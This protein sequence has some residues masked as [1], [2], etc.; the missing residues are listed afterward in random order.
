MDRMNELFVRW[1]AFYGSLPPQRRF[2]L[3][4]SLVASLALTGA[5][6]AWATNDPMV[7]LFDQPLDPKTT[8]QVI[9][10]LKTEQIKYRLERGTD[11]ILVPNHQKVGCVRALS[12]V[13]A[14]VD[15]AG[16]Q[17]MLN[18]AQKLKLDDK[19]ATDGVT[20]IEENQ[21]PEKEK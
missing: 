17:P 8:A 2:S 21:E 1:M 6:V 4:M 7:A 5:V 18:D 11:R 19:P 13:H 3:V 10:Q 14:I 20:D 9:E 16:I 12:D 15:R